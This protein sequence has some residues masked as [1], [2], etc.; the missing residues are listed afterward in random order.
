MMGD[1][2]R[3]SLGELAAEAGMTTRNV[4]AYQTRGLIPPAH[5][6]GRRSEYTMRH[7]DRLRAIHRARAQGASLRLI[8][9]QLSRGGVIDL[10]RLADGW[11]P[12][13]R[14]VREPRRSD[15]SGLLHRARVADDPLVLAI[16]EDLISAGV[17]A[18][19]GGR[20]VAGR[21]LVATV[22]A[23][24]RHGVALDLAL[25]VAVRAAE[26][27]AALAGRLGAILQPG[28]STIV[29]QVAELAA[30]VLRGV[31]VDGLAPPAGADAARS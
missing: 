20:I 8:A 21:E 3:F 9:D 4:R 22:T 28:S 15:L 13:Q 10:T 5:R 25:T 1:E 29:D 14:P 6:V 27:A 17:V 23:L 24:Y 18:R 2:K 7:L 30:G 16:V 19:D 26:S 31:L 12:E 11:L